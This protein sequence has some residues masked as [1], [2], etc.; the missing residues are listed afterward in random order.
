MVLMKLPLWRLTGFLLSSV[1]GSYTLVTE[2][3]KVPGVKGAFDQALAKR[4]LPFVFQLTELTRRR[5]ERVLSVFGE[6][7]LD[8]CSFILPCETYQ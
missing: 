5:V 7:T 8:E 2:E 4:H 1:S 6:L 3:I